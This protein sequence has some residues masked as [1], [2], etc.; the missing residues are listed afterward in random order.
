MSVVFACSS[1]KAPD[2]NQ[3]GVGAANGGA[4]GSAGQSDAATAGLGSGGKAAE[5][6]ATGSGGTPS[7]AGASAG[8]A[9]A[10]PIPQTAQ[11]KFIVVDQFGYRPDGEKIAVLRDPQV[12]FDAADAFTPGAHYS[13]IDARTGLPALSGAPSAWN[14]GATDDSSGDKAWSFDFSTVTAP[15]TY[16]V[17]DVDNAVRSDLFDISDTVYREVLKRAVRMFFYQRAG[18]AKDAKWAGAAWADTADHVGPGQDHNCRAFSAKTDASTEKDVWGGW[19]DAGDFNKYTN[20]TAGYVVSLLHAY[21]ENK[22]IWSDDYEI[23]ESGNGIPDVLDEAK[24][25]LDYL[26][27]LQQADGSVLSIVGEGSGS[28]PSAA[29]DPSYYGP[30]STSATT[31]TAAAFALGA[32]VLGSLGNA[33]MTA[34]A[35]DLKSRATKAWAWADA[36]PSVVFRNNEGDSA[37]LG[38]GQQETDDY[39]RTMM[40]VEASVYLFELTQDPQ[41]QAFFDANYASSNL[42]KNSYAAP[43]EPATQLALLYYTSLPS[44]TAAVKSNIFKAYSSGMAGTDNFGAQTAKR[45]PYGAYLKD[46]T[47]GSNSTKSNQGS[48]FFDFA[49]YA[50]DPSKDSDA[51]L[52]AERYVHY[53]HGVNALGFVYLSNM[54]DYG[55]TQGATTF[56]HTWYA[57]GSALWEKVGVSSYGPPP[58]FLTGGPNPSY[59]V[60]GCCATSSCGGLSCTSEPLSPP[61]G[62]PPQKSY[63]DF[64]TSWPIDS[65]SVTEPSDGYQVAYIRLLSKFV[66]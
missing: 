41:F 3:N 59:A 40:K 44:A 25:G 31:S 32:T 61:L 9:G 1:N 29:T 64:N 34:Y 20:W 58:G 23:P 6:G 12:G 51:R 38:S 53:L 33:S 47:W 28:P 11:S 39:G 60:D 36:N 27:R 14:G 15:G 5:A 62:Q 37:G 8:A 45:D 30:P 50:V 19:F 43:W 26:G 10:A 49:T 21:L 42:V 65:W 66:K 57:H 18:Q 17:L 56:F 22:A 2:A 16:Y 54:F 7:G 13:L 52:A 63:K 55:A 4:S 48:M 35:S 46:Y 24:W